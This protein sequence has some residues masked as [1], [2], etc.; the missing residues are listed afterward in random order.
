MKLLLLIALERLGMLGPNEGPHALTTTA[1][2]FSAFHKLYKS[3]DVKSMLLVS[4]DAV[5][6]PRTEAYRTRSR[7]HWFAS[8]RRLRRLQRC[9]T[10]LENSHGSMSRTGVR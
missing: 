9:V 10:S 6:R 4:V 7:G 8:R 3:L 2:A 1:G 5:G